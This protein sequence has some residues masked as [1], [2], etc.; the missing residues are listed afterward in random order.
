MVNKMQAASIFIGYVPLG[1]KIPE[2]CVTVLTCIHS[3]I[4]YKNNLGKILLLKFMYH[5]LTPRV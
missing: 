3:S 4:L 1:C 2:K 5:S